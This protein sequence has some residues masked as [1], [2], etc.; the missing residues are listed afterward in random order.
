MDREK[1]N[2]AEVTFYLKG[3][4]WT[5]WELSANEDVADFLRALASDGGDAF[6]ATPREPRPEHLKDWEYEL[7][8]AF[9]DTLGVRYIEHTPG[10]RKAYTIISTEDISSISIAF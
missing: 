10:R 7:T 5:E 8:V 3:N 6:I 4:G 2:E 1:I 9:S